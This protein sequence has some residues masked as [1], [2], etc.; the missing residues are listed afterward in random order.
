SAGLLGVVS[1]GGLIW[2]GSGVFATME[3]AFAQIFGISQRD[4]V[5]QK[6]MGFVMMIV[7]IVAVGVTVG[8]NVL[9]GLLPG[10]WLLSFVIGATGAAREP[11]QRITRG[12]A[13]ERGDRAEEGRD[14]RRVGAPSRAA[15]WQARGEVGAATTF[16]R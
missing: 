3:F 14:A 2:T 13:G 9:A 5:R 4:T 12:G 8:A 6:L 7:L 11:D 1:I 15:A 16:V 10:A